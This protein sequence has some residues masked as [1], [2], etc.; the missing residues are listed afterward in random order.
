MGSTD[1]NKPDPEKFREFLA[2]VENDSKL[3]Q[4]MGKRIKLS[5]S[6]VEL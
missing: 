1:G 5:E 4:N 2:R 3:P 6:K